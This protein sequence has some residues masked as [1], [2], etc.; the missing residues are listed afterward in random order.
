MAIAA[1]TTQ[2][3]NQDKT[4]DQH[5]AE[6]PALSVDDRAMGDTLRVLFP[7][8]W[9]HNRPDLKMRI[10]IA[11]FILVLAKLV[12]VLVPYSYKWLTDSLTGE[13]GAPASIPEWLIV[14]MMLVIAYGV[15]R[16]MMVGFNELRNALFAKVG[17]HA[18]RSLA[19]ETFGHIHRL[20]LALPLAAAHRRS[21]AH[22]RARHQGH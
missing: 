7:Y 1:D 4:Q 3:K 12:T 18:V 8:I 14:P 10:Y 2:D 5:Q 13:L 16:L 11:L 17:Q 9:P 6:K 20:S 21:V 19:N 22:H 15:G